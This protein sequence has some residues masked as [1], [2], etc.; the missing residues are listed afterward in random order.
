MSGVLWL[1]ACSSDSTAPKGG[2]VVK[3]TDAGAEARALASD[4]AAAPLPRDA[5]APPAD[6]DAAAA[7]VP[8][9]SGPVDG[10]PSK[11]SETGL[12]VD[13]KNETPAPGVRA[14]QPKYVLWADGATKNRWVYL[15]PGK[16]IDTSDM[17]F[18]VY[19]VGT[20]V[21]KDFALNG[22]RIETRYLHKVADDE[23][24][25]V[26]YQW[27][28]EQTEA[29][30]VPDGVQNANGTP[31]DIPQQSDCNFC[32]GNMPDKLLGVTAIQLS[33]DLPGMKLADLIS[34][35]RLTLPPAGNFQIPGAPVAEK[36]LGYLHANC[37]HCHNPNS[38]VSVR[39]S[40]DLWESTIALDTVE[41]TTAFR[42]AVLQ[43]NS[44]LPDL[45]IIEPGKPDQSEM[46]LRIS[47]RGPGGIVTQMPPIATETVDQNGVGLIR[48]WIESMP[49]ADGGLPSIHDAGRD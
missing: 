5:S 18:W 26:A 24:T 34:E 17:D 12:F 22:K 30:A 6:A 10:F 35:N 25:M 2:P 44:V 39:V 7:A 16:T 45:H 36:A 15:P 4:G 48:A 42:S 1:S 20:K 13:M 21:W 14:Y 46:F 40:L 32:H 38:S 11:L 19:P 27:N 31:H 29:L 8:D 47:R 41:H 9:A 3:P 23:W 43:P 49:L 33:H 37:G 28:D